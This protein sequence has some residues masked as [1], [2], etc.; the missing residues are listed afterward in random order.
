MTRQ[1]LKAA[2]LAQVEL[3]ISLDREIES[4]KLDAEDKAA[5]YWERSQIKSAIEIL[6][7]QID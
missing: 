7:A 3:L 5:A 6:T 2:R 1:E 4:G